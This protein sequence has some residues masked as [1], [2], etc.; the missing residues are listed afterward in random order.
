MT[1]RSILFIRR[2]KHLEKKKEAK[3]RKRKKIL[4][5]AWEL[6]R[7]KGYDE[8]KVEDITNELGIS[9]G[10]FYTYFKTKDEVLYEILEKIRNE[11]I[12]RLE[13][14]DINQTPSEILEDY[15]IKKIDYTIKILSNMKLDN[16]EKNFTNP[17]IRNFFEEL[18]KVSIKFIRENIVEKFNKINGNKYNPEIISEFVLV[19]IDGFLY[20][21]FVYKNM[22][23]SDIIN[24]EN[25]D[26]SKSSIKE[27]IKFIDNALK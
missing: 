9:K 13:K 8:T 21:E 6:F 26:K 5:K 24:I 20:D 19:S 4:D 1:Y 3:K 18:R 2:V 25:A 16:I 10:S 22:K 27:I 17:K 11:S 7:K 23:N 12:E 14:I 15:I